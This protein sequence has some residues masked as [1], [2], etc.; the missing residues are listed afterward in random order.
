MAKFKLP[1]HVHR[2]G[3]KVKTGMHWHFYAWRGGPRF[4]TGGDKFPTD[5]AFFAAFAA[6]I[7]RP[8]PA[9]LM[10][11][12]LVD[13]FLDSPAMP[14][15]ARTRADYRKWALR[16]ADAFKDDPAALFEDPG[17]RGEVNDWRNTWAHSPKQYDYAGTVATLILNWAVEEGRIGEH[18]CHKLR[19]VYEADRAHIV[20]A[21]AHREVMD[22]KAP[23]WV[24]RILTMACE[25]GLRPADLCRLSWSHIETTK[26]GMQIK[27]RTNKRKR[28]AHIPVTPAV[29]AVLDCTPRDRLLI[30]VSERGKPLTPH[31]AS[32][33]L[34]QWRD[35][36]GLTPEAVGHDLRLQDCRGTA[37]TRLLNAGLTLKEI[38]M[39]MGWSLRHAAAVIEHYA[40]V[41]PDESDSI[42]VKLAQA[43]GGNT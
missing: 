16:F 34:R 27:L 31:R 41:S 3:R 13:A 28:L 29:G 30:L 38:A 5:P 42:L 17:S 6:A 22:T 10:T 11:P 43:N 35:K 40:T 19:K 21:P 26:G 15:A 8:K 9:K 7:A 2:V 32:E 12:D 1:D 20:W 37:A 33:G 36:A 25:T 39:H 24:R 14:K 4:W 23:D 18:H